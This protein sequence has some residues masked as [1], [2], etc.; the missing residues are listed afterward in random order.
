MRDWAEDQ[1]GKLREKEI[2]LTFIRHGFTKENLEKRY[3]GA[4]DTPLSEEGKQSLRQKRGKGG[5]PMAGRLFTSPMARCIQT[6]GIL[7]PGIAYQVIP[8]WTE[9]DFGL[10][11]GKNYGELKETPEYQAW[12]QSGGTLPFPKGEGREAFIRRS[13]QG[14]NRML[15]G[16]EPSAELLADGETW[17]V[18]AAAIVHGG[19]V[20][21]V[22]SSLFG[23][24]YFDYQV[25]CGEGYTCVFRYSGGCI[26]LLE[27]KRIC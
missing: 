7:F 17:R 5:Y 6:A 27:L 10:F 4:A 12:L 21:A 14:F 19:T 9:I 13:M 20:M 15:A 11:E 26:K 23:G 3:L 2:S 22:C 24:D 18:E 8:E 16:L 25:G 1:V